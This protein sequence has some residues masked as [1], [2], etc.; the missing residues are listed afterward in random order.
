MNKI[1]PHDGEELI[2]V[3]KILLRKRLEAIIFP[4]LK[5]D[6]INKIYYQEYRFYCPECDS[7]FSYNSFLDRLY[8]LAPN[9]EE[10]YSDV[11]NAVIIG[12]WW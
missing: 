11:H 5:E 4:I 2:M 10:R 8:D 7:L 1:C 3:D 12:G 6:R 9:T